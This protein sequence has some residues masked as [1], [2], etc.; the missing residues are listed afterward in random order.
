MTQTDDQWFYARNNVQTGPISKANLTALVQDGGLAATDLIWKT[1]MANWQPAGTF[2][3]FFPQAIGTPLQDASAPPI[4][5]ALPYQTPSQF[6]APTHV[7]A[8]M[9]MRMLLPVDRSGWYIAAGYLGLL[10]V[11]CIFAP[12]SFIVGIIAMIDIRKHPEKR[13]MGRAI[14]AI[15]MGALFSVILLLMIIIT[16]QAKYLDKPG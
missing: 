4:L 3:E 9:G 11:L 1:G 2:A 12:F 6:M 13:G 8:S 14:F 15:I 7:P 5:N 10:S 16:S